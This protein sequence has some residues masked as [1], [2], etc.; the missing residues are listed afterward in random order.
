[1]VLRGE[2]LYPELFALCIYALRQNAKL[3][4]SK[5]PILSIRRILAKFLGT[6]DIQ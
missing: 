4:D 5:V 2:G 6:K 1:M 3:L